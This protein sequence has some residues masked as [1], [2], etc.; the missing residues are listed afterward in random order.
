[1]GHNCRNC[2]DIECY[3]V[4]TGGDV[5][6]GWMWEDVQSAEGEWYLQQCGVG[7]NPFREDALD[8]GTKSS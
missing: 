4:L 3:C 6:C 8:V 5:K 7:H 2:F 1:M